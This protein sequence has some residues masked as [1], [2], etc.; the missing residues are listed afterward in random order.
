M[1]LACALAQYVSLLCVQAKTAVGVG[2]LAPNAG[3]NDEELPSYEEV[4]EEEEARQQRRGQPADSVNSIDV[5]D[6][7]EVMDAEAEVITM[8]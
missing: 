7:E 5:G 4:M 8:S 2:N 1:C 3:D 6:N